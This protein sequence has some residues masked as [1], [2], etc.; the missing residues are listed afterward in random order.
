VRKQAVNPEYRLDEL[1]VAKSQSSGW[2]NRTPLRLPEP[3]VVFLCSPTVDA[4]VRPPSK[5]A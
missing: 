1:V 4:L 5:T 2:G 3:P